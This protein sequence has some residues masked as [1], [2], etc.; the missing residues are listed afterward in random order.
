MNKCIQYTEIVER[1]KIIIDLARTMNFSNIISVGVGCAYLE[2]NIK[3]NFPL[4]NITCTDFAPKTIWNLKKV[5]IECDLIKEFDILND[6]WS[7]QNGTL[8]LLHR[9]DTEFSNRQ[10]E[11]IFYNMSCSNVRYILFIPS[12]FLTLRVW[13]QEKKRYL[14]YRMLKLPISFAG[15][16]RTRSTFISLWLPYYNIVK[17]IKV[18]KLTGFLLERK[19]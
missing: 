3:N 15:Y 1:A 16:L 2:Y 13:I 6:N 8:Y 12:T 10:W 4:L 18:G 11:K 14:K 5:F 9:V 19:I 17:E 7:N